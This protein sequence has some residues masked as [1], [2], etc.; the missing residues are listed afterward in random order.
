MLPTQS[1]PTSSIQRTICLICLVIYCTAATCQGVRE[2]TQ[3][4]TVRNSIE[5]TRLL[6]LD[7][8]N[9]ASSEPAVTLPAPDGQ[10]FVI[11]T[12][13]GDLSRNLNIE[14]ILLFD[15]REV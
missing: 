15:M 7:Q 14:E 5:M 11:L 4:F 1:A 8:A 2:K 13:R 10:H 12:R 3:P 9:G 6:E